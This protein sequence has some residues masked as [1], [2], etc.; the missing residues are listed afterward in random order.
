MPQDG[1]GAQEGGCCPKT[2]LSVADTKVVKPVVCHQSRN[3]VAVLRR[4]LAQR[5]QSSDPMG[6][7]LLTLAQCN[8]VSGLSPQL[9]AGRPW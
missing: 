5:Q 6:T 9:D 1:C 3:T 7:G 4:P 8:R 2:M